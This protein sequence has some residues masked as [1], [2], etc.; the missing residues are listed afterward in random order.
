[1]TSIIT[2]DFHLTQKDIITKYARRELVEKS[3]SEHIHFFHLNRLSSSIVIKV[4]LDLTMTITAHTLYRMM[5]KKLTGFE[6]A[7]AKTLFRNFIDTVA[8]IVID[9]PTIQ[10]KVLKKVH[11]PP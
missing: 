6:N 7:E 8:D 9:Y 10:I 4:D 1:M 2:N 11:Y 5:A 3:I